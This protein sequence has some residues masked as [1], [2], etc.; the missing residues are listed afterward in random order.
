MR[1]RICR[2]L[3]GVS[4]FNPHANGG[5]RAVFAGPLVRSLRFLVPA[6]ERTVRRVIWQ[7][8]S[9]V[10]LEFGERPCSRL[11][12]GSRAERSECRIEELALELL[13]LPVLHGSLAQRGKVIPRGDPVKILLR[14]IGQNAGKG[15]NRRRLD[16]HC[17]QQ[18]VGTAIAAGL[19]DR[20]NLHDGKPLSR[21]P[22]NQFL[23]CLCISD[24]QILCAANGK[25]RSQDTRDFVLGIQLKHTRVLQG[26]ARCDNRE[27]TFSVE[28]LVFSP[29]AH[30]V[31]VPDH[32]AYFSVTIS[33]GRR[34]SRT[35]PLLIGRD[36][37]SVS[38]RLA[39]HAFRTGKVV[40]SVSGPRPPSD[41]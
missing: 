29:C 2:L 36:F 17:A 16:C 34:S 11:I 10:F 4:R 15:G 14:Q 7:P 22:G 6:H 32:S 38:S 13:N 26:R 40:V 5:W 3:E 31:R 27:L 19:V 39:S 21:S 9:I 24:P 20:Q 23:Q 37:S 12:G 18:I 30:S 28:E 25:G 35:L 33:K 1:S 8:V 41:S